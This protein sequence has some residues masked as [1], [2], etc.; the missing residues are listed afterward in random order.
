MSETVAG[1]LARQVL[2]GL[3]PALAERDFDGFSR[4]VGAVQDLQAG[5]VARPACDDGG[6]ERA[7]G[8]AV[9]ED[10]GIQV[11]EFHGSASWGSGVAAWEA[12]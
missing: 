1:A 12:L 5:D 2:V 7:A 6:R 8:R 10:A 3:M 4:A 11:Q 9:A